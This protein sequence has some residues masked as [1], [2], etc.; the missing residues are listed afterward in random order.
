[1]I[2]EECKA[3]NIKFSRKEFEE[4]YKIHQE[5]SRTASAG[6][7]KSGLAD[8]S[9]ET[10]RLHTATHLLLAA[11]RKILEDNSIQQKGSN[12]TSERLRFDFSYPRK[13]TD[14]ELKDIEKEVNSNIKKGCNV[15]REEMS[16]EEA[17][18]RG[19]TGI[20]EHKYGEIVSVYTIEK[21]S[22]EI[23][24]GPHVKNTCELGRFKILKEESSSS[25]VRRIKA[26]LE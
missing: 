26:V 1:M 23:C 3:R 22:K 5:L 19:I 18:K 4:E 20:F 8:S 13:L 7:F 14:R 21:C 6:K 9:I 24:T 12:I 10:T 15:I 11:I 16:L 2:E 25:G 17:K